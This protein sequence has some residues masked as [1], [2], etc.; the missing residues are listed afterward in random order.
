VL[1][2]FLRELVGLLDDF[3]V[4]QEGLKAKASLFPVILVCA[5][6]AF[7]GLEFG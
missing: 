5:V 3:V 2:A 4:V 1:R 7:Q 6:P